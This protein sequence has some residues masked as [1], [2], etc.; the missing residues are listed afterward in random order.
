MMLPCADVGI[1]AIAGANAQSAE[2]RAGKNNLTL[3]ETLVFLVGRSYPVLAIVKTDRAFRII[4]R[5]GVWRFR[6]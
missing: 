5:A 3:V 2:D 1:E 4:P 6:N